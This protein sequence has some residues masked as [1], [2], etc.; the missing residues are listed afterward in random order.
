VNI[1]SLYSSNTSLTAA[2]V[3][4]TASPAAAK[5]APAAI[6]TAAVLHGN[7][8]LTDLV[9]NAKDLGPQTKAPGLP[10]GAGGNTPQLPGADGKN[11]FGSGGPSTS[12]FLGD[13]GKY[14]S[15]GKNG[16]GG[17]GGFGGTGGLPAGLGDF[18]F[19]DDGSTG[20]GGGDSSKYVPGTGRS[21]PGTGGTVPS[22]KSG[23]PSGLDGFGD[24]GF[25]GAPQ[26]SGP[27]SLAGIVDRNSPGY[28]TDKGEGQRAGAVVGWLVGGVGGA[29]VGSIVGSLFD[30]GKSASNI[31]KADTDKQTKDGEGSIN[32]I[33]L[34]VAPATPDDKK[35]NGGMPADDG[36]GGTSTGGVGG[37]RSN[38]YLPADDGNGGTSTGGVGGPRSNVASQYMP[39]DDGGGVGPNLNGYFPAD[40]NTGPVNPHSAGQSVA[41]KLNL[42]SIAAYAVAR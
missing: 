25:T 8:Q 13:L 20:F 32:D 42:A 30:S 23:L 1:T 2:R 29:A 5:I 18:G 22:G 9:W 10:A 7:D 6:Q 40:D 41:A 35:P 15:T 38:V 3:A 37:P 12:D 27:N 36:Y 31:S 24:S 26:G 21:I 16:P 19:G 28:G 34:S 14:G 4:Q 11:P 17:K 39:S 33:D